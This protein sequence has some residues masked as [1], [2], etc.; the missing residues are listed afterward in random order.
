MRGNTFSSLLK[1]DLKRHLL[2]GRKAA[3]SIERYL[4]GE[5]IKAGRFLEWKGIELEPKDI[6]HAE[7]QIMPCLSVADRK[8]SFEEM[9][10]G[11]S[12]EQAKKEAGRCLKICGAQIKVM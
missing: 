12:E 1:E 9:D 2:L 8:N 4:K 10:L 7:R 5:D 3:I 6:Q 11:F